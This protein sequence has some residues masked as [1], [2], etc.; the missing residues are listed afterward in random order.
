MDQDMLGGVK[1]LTV[2]EAQGQ[3]A[4]LNAEA[5]QGAVMVLVVPKDVG[6]FVDA[7]FNPI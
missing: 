1:T 7:D 2:G 5:Y 6:Q 4:E 3:L